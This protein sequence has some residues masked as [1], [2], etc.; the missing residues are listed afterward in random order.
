MEIKMLPVGACGVLAVL[1]D[2]ISET[3]GAQVAALDD[4]VRRARLYAVTETVPA[5][6]SLLVRY[7]P[8]RTDYEAVSIDL[9][10]LA[11]RIDA[12]S[13]QTGRIV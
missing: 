8:L 10:R 3:T 1:G 7:D 13:A 6:A 4:A 9:T 12:G 2:R 11:A 5:Y